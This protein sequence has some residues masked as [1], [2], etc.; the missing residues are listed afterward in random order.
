MDF[1]F[2]M[3]EFERLI[4]QLDKSKVTVSAFVGERYLNLIEEGFLEALIYSSR[5]NLEFLGSNPQIFKPGMP[6]KVYVSITNDV[7]DLDSIFYSQLIKIKYNFM[8]I[9]CNSPSLT[10]NSYHKGNS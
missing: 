8:H 7:C 2:P 4:P 6:F 1:K 9:Q 5:I 10:G 3:K